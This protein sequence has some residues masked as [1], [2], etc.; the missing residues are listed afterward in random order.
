MNYSEKFFLFFL[1]IRLYICKDV[2]LYLVI[3][4]LLPQT[5]TDFFPRRTN[6]GGKL[7]QSVFVCLVCGKKRNFRWGGFQTRPNISRTLDLI[8]NHFNPGIKRNA[9][10]IVS[11]PIPLGMGHH[12][13]LDAGYCRWGNLSPWNI[14]DSIRRVNPSTP[15]D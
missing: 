14:W 7:F 1:P 5:L 4:L 8:I 15:W 2:T 9:N 13:D 6:T 11:G 3:R 10:K 12:P